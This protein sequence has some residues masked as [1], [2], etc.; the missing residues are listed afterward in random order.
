MTGIEL[1]LHLSEEFERASKEGMFVTYMTVAPRDRILFAELQR[2]RHWDS[3]SGGR[4]EPYLGLPVIDGEATS[5]QGYLKT[6]G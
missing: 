5:F 4:S 2:N 6:A 3:E 1:G